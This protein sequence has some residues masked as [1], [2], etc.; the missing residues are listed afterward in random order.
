MSAEASWADA[1]AASRIAR[2][3]EP[4]CDGR[5]SRTG[6][7]PAGR[8]YGDIQAGPVTKVP[9]AGSSG[10]FEEEASGILEKVV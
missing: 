8:G 4:A 10:V 9:A 6:R 2:I 5:L 7:A 3:G 1:V